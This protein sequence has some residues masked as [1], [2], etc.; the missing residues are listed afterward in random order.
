M[1]VA[2][3]PPLEPPPPLDPVIEIFEI[4][5]IAQGSEE[6][7]ALR[8]GIPTASCFSMVLAQGNDGE[9]SKTR[10]RYKRVL[11][12]ELLTGRPGEGKIV[13]AAMQRGKDMEA[14]AFDHYAQRHFAAVRPVGFMRRKL[15]NGRW[16]GCSPDGL[17]ESRS[18]GLEIKSMQPD[19]LIERLERGAGMPSE[20][21]AQVQGTMWI[22]DL[23]EMDVLLFYSGMPVI[24]KFTVRRD[25]TYIRQLSRAVEVF[26]FELHQLVE[27]V[28]K[29]GI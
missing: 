6:W 1:P 4:D 2:K 7:F 22:G 23:D 3:K 11:A 15:P 5:Q 28:R 27:R 25:N 14:E 10:E 16:V 19:L 13:T 24:P 9:A 12:G 20:H 26:D 29:M 8:L 18:S 17:I 21:R